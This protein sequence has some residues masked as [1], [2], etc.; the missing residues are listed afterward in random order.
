MSSA[1]PVKGITV[2]DLHEITRRL[3]EQGLGDWLIKVPYTPGQ[4]TVGATPAAPV[5][6]A[7]IGFDWNRGTVM[8]TPA[9]ELGPANPDFAKLHRML[10]EKAG[11]LYRA[12]SILKTLSEKLSPA[13]YA[14][15]AGALGVK[16]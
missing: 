14:R 4:V 7:N 8:L 6:D 15:M 11:Q 5:T 13:E 10:D 3:R 16:K 9:V 1:A 2:T 12:A